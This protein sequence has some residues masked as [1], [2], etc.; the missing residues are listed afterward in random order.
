VADEALANQRLDLRAIVIGRRKH[1]IFGIE[2]N[3]PKPMPKVMAAPL[4]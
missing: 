1:L 4:E 3:A 2:V